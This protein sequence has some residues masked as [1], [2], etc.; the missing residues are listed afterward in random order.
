M[1][2]DVADLLR[3]L[4]LSALVSASL[5][6]I[7]RLVLRGDTR[8]NVILSSFGYAVEGTLDVAIQNFSVPDSIREKLDSSENAEK[9]GTI[10]FSLSRG[11]SI[12]A[13]VGNN[14]Y[15]CQLQQ[16]DQGFDALFF[17]VDLPNKRLNIF[18]SGLGQK[19]RLCSSHQ[20]CSIGSSIRNASNSSPT[21]VIPDKSQQ[22]NSFMDTIKRWFTGGS[23]LIPYEDFIP[24]SQND[25]LYSANISV[26]FPAEL[27]GKYYLIY[28][29]CFKYKE[30]GYS[31]R[32]GVD[33]SIFMLE[34]NADSFLS[35]GD[36][37]K[38]RVYLYLSMAFL[39]AAIIWS[40]KLCISPRSS[41]FRVHYVMTALVFLKATSLFFH[42]VNYYFVSKYGHQRE[43]W[44]FVFYVTHL[45]KGALLF[46]SIILIGTGYTF[47]KN[48]LT[49]RD[50]RVML[51]VLP[52]Q[53]LDNIALV[54]LEEGELGSKDHQLFLELF[55][56]IDILCCAFVFFPI[57][58][59]M[60]YL[61]QG[62]ASDGKAAFNLQKLQLFRQFYVVT[63]FYIY[64]TRISKYLLQYSIPF[65][66]DWVVVCLIEVSTL[67]YFYWAGSR[68]QPQP[69]NP[70]L[71][72]EQDE[73]DVDDDDDMALTRNGLLEVV[74]SRS[75][76]VNNSSDS[77]D[78]DNEKEKIG[79]KRVSDAA[80]RSSYRSSDDG[81]GSSPAV[82]ELT[83]VNKKI[84][85]YR[86]KLKEIN[87]E[88]ESQSF[89]SYYAY[90]RRSRNE[91][92]IAGDVENFLSMSRQ[93]E[94]HKGADNPQLARIRQTFEKKN[95][96]HAH[97]T[98]GIQKKLAECEARLVQL[99]HQNA[100]GG[101][102]DS[103]QAKGPS[104]ISSVSHGLWKTGANL[105]GRADAVMAAPIELA[106]K[107]RNT[108]G[109]S[110]DVNRDMGEHGNSTFY[111]TS[112]AELDNA[113]LQPPSVKSK[114]STLPPGSKLFAPQ[115]DGDKN[116]NASAL[117]D[118]SYHSVVNNSSSN[119]V[120]FE[121]SE[122]NTVKTAMGRLEERLDRLNKHVESELLYYS[123][124][125]EEER[126]RSSKLEA[127]L[128]ETI[129]LHQGEFQAL[130]L[131]QSSMANRLDYQ[132]NERFL[133]V[134]DR[135]GAIHNDLQRIENTLQE[136]NQRY[137]LDEH[138][139]GAAA[140]SAVNILV[141]TFLFGIY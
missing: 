130:K 16:T 119:D 87:L 127:L 1:R 11:I 118:T 14:P 29:N 40:Y 78:S 128:N 41:R 58:W 96:R 70:Y 105:K 109:S 54:I 106:Q 94:T 73:R 99:R 69:S 116:T 121:L 124:A 90:D 13:G 34:T 25:N 50:R 56:F 36:I 88:R 48:F 129:D 2:Q 77:S 114:A 101:L 75:D 52:L 59:S 60:Q 64:F 79:R 110:D 23:S 113:L 18:R 71:R 93:A 135:V 107:L 100:N 84:E 4:L 46:G 37:P 120:S 68:F 22:S 76:R 137:S 43:I 12:S 117:N 89:S 20:E 10:G 133:I 104:V 55:I 97:D 136:A 134:D 123:K 112:D 15:I 115:Q 91:R 51:I 24:L 72:L 62:A 61:S 138:R 6:K 45:L 111:A 49:E 140:L 81:T 47:F 108:L 80:D 95:K 3:V 57:I 39:V 9:A 67:F 27:T 139:W 26:R 126:F 92:R 83:R 8:R 122:L 19:I 21:A 86:E 85:H 141:R 102:L 63:I 35:A 28:H 5:S 32:I 131:E 7:H 103:N 42:G 66:W 65:D 132:Y 98:E 33:A 53:V 30:H 82:D 17:F 38:P 74:V 44:A 125:L 31:D